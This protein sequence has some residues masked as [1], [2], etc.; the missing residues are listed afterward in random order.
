MKILS[1]TII[2]II[3]NCAQIQAQQ[4]PY[5]NLSYNYN[6]KIA[7]SRKL[8]TDVNYKR[9]SALSL[10]IFNK[11]NKLLQTIKIA[12]GYLYDTVFRNNNDAKSYI[13]GKNKQVEVIDYD[14]GDLIVAD[15]NFDG[16]ED[17]AIKYDS[18]GNGGPLYAFYVQDNKGH[19]VIDHFL[20]DSVRS[21]PRYINH[22]HKTITTQIHA[23][24]H[25]EGQKTFEYNP[26]NKRWHLIKWI[27]VEG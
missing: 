1:V 11:Q 24:V 3:A 17:F 10:L 25:Q 26:R 12:P 7:V 6:L 18:G 21:F 4:T 15:L 23:N 2:L 16:K 13:T 27:M 9:I 20:T 19:F 8:D 5:D 14:F 22:K